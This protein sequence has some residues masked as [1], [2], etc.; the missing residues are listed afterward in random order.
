MPRIRLYL[1]IQGP[2]KGS[3]SDQTSLGKFKFSQIVTNDADHG[4]TTT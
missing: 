2:G 1:V 4:M 3:A